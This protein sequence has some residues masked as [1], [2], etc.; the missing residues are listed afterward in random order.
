MTRPTMD[1][2]PRDTVS[3]EKFKAARAQL[4]Q[5]EKAVTYLSQA[6]V[7]ARRRLPMVKVD[8]PARFCF[9]TLHGEQSLL[10]LFDGHKQLIIYHVMLA[11]ED[12]SSVGYDTV[13][14][15]ERGDDMDR[16]RSPR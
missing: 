12:V 15:A 2:P 3:P 11:T 9:D 4:L 5:D 13:R 6:V 16:F 7:A 8:D 14:S 10:D 1:E